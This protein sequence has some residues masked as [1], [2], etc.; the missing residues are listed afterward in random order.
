LCGKTCVDGHAAEPRGAQGALSLPSAHLGV[1]A[2][3][4][5]CSGRV[6]M[7]RAGTR[8]SKELE[9]EESGV[10][11]EGEASNMTTWNE[12]SGEEVAAASALCCQLAP[13]EGA[14]AKSSEMLTGR[15]GGR[16]G[17]SRSDQCNARL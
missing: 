2:R 11:Q 17:G 8:Q 15:G 1:S 3:G 12:E 6:G 13:H 16:G 4:G 10:A 9:T 14:R 7:R 5:A